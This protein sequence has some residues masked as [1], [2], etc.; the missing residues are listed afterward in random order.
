MTQ[1]ETVD[2]SPPSLAPTAR[3]PT[4]FGLTTAEAERRLAEVGPNALAEAKRPS[5][6][7][8][9]LA[10]LVHLFALLLWAGAALALIGGLPELTVAIVVVILVN[11][12]FAFVQEYRAERAVEALRQHA[13]ARVFACAG[14]A[15]RS[16]SASEEVVPGDV[17]LLA[18]GDQGR[19][20]RRRSSATT[21]ASTSR[22]SPASPTRPRPTS[23][24]SRART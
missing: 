7:A 17:L 11:A 8:S 5:T 15:F 18:P 1:L 21:C 12:V 3:P 20:R 16:R 6:C 13:A 2:R 10:N 9:S 24:S 23:R 4:V 14:T 19:R 22:R